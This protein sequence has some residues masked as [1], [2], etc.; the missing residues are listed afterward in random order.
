[1]KTSE[2]KTKV[3]ELYNKYFPKSLCA[4]KVSSDLYRSMW[5]DCYLAKDRS[6]FPNGIDL[7]DM[8]NISFRIEAGENKELSKACV[9]EDGVLPETILITNR[10]NS[11]AIKPPAGSYLCYYRTNIQFRKTTGSAEKVLE[12]LEKFFTK[13]KSSLEFDLKADKI[14]KNHLD[15]L[16]LKLERV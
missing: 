12:T 11:Y 9:K 3:T 6:E 8:F 2:F 4:V 13:M 1:M 10:S 15:L 7:N 16:L 14:H 5:I